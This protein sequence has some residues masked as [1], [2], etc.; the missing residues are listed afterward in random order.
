MTRRELDAAGITDP[1]LRAAY[2]HCRQLNARHGRTYFLAARLLPLERRSAV[3]ALY[4]FARWADDIVDDLDRRLTGHARDRLLRRLEADLAHGLR[5]GGGDEPVV[6]AVADTAARYAIDHSLFADFLVSM[7]SD[8]SVTDY[9]AYSDLLAYMHGSAAVI[10]LQILPVLGTTGPREEAAP[11]AA[12]LGVAFQ[13]TNF[14][15]DVGEDLDRGR[16]Y[17]PADLLAAH[18]VDRALLEWS[19]RTGRRDRRI[20]AALVAAEALTRGVYREAEPGIAILDP[21]VRPCIRTAFTLY[22]GILDAIA[23]QDYAVLHRRA[24]VSRG[25]RATTAAYGALCTVGAR[26]RARAGAGAVAGGRGSDGP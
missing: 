2:A 9:P 19:R 25:R 15:R 16:V 13:L 26:C 8:L 17:L 14:L 20:R 3:H 24:V 22:G 1:T 10:G 4:G 7:R 18:G 11:H 5:A 6:R 23:G 12:A 21:Q